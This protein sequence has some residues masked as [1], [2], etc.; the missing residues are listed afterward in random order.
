M[1]LYGSEL[2]SQG[3][4]S[5]LNRLVKGN[6]VQEQPLAYAVGGNGLINCYHSDT[7]STT[8][9]LRFSELS[10]IAGPD[11]YIYNPAY[12]DATEFSHSQIFGGRFSGSG[13]CGRDGAIHVPSPSD[14]LIGFAS[15]PFP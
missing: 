3:T 14:C 6:A 2:F 5:K 7:I 10:S 13:R 11:D 9:R 15:A 4:A 1:S 8:L 12:M